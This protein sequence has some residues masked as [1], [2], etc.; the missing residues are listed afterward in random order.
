MLLYSGAVP[1]VYVLQVLGLRAPFL[2]PTAAG[3]LKLRPRVYL[4]GT[5]ADAGP[6]A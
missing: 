1:L 3:E 5:A 4:P 6:S 2:P